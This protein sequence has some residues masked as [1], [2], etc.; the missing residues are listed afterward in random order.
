M[1][2][3]ILSFHIHAYLPSRLHPSD[4]PT[5]VSYAFLFSMRALCTAH[6]LCFLRRHHHHHQV[7]AQRPVA[8]VICLINKTNYKLM[9]EILMYF[10]T[11]SFLRH[12]LVQTFFFRTL[13]S[14]SLHL[15]PSLIVRD[16]F[17]A[18]IITGKICSFMTVYVV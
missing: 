11:S 10:R 6:L 18:I 2:I 17:T 7:Q 3:L 16:C 9:L 4:F 8:I 5:K 1:Y 12:V 15:R 14:P 13:F